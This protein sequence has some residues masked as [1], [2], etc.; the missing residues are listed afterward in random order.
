MKNKVFRS[1]QLFAFDNNDYCNFTSSV[2]KAI[3]GKDIL[4]CIWNLEGTDLLAISGQQGLTI[5]RSADTIEISSKDTQGGW[6]SYL[7]GMKEWSIDNDGLF[8]PNDQ[9]HSILSKAFESGDPVCVKVVDNKRKVGMFGGLA[10]VTD[11]P[12][13]AP[14][15]DSVTYSITLSGMGALIDLSVDPVSPDTM[16]EGTAALEM[17]TVVSVSGTSSGDTAIYVNPAKGESNKYLYRTGA[18][19]LAYPS[20]G[21]VISQTE[22]DG[23]EEISGLTNGDQIMIIETDTAGRALKAGIAEITTNTGA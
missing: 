13:E 9:S 23:M 4:L 21:E 16:P 3:A 10:V 14:Y 19:P 22:W 12:I 6:K 7:A 17:L 20:Y 1:L 15:D 5:N 18:A 2:A 8:V 11:Y